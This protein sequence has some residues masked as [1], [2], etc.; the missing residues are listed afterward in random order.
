[1]KLAIVGCGLIGAKRLRSLGPDHTVVALADPVA[2]RA[3]ALA[4]QAAVTEPRCHRPKTASF[5]TARTPSDSA[6]AN[7]R[8]G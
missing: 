1:M 3:Q 7:R 4:A 6:K 8:C 5:M 2:A